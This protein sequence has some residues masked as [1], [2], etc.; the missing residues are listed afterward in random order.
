MQASLFLRLFKTFFV[1]VDRLLESLNMRGLRGHKLL[2]AGLVLGGQVT[3]GRRQNSENPI[4]ITIHSK[5]Q[6]P[7]RALKIP[8]ANP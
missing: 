3:T 6:N 5:I 2:L 7:S 8:E 4:M 1:N